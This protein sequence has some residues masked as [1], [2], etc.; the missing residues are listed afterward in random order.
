MIGFAGAELGDLLVVGR[1]LVQDGGNGVVAGHGQV[2]GKEVPSPGIHSAGT[3]SG[4][5]GSE[6]SMA[7]YGVISAAGSAG[8]GPKRRARR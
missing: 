7:G 8:F 4:M 5:P 1:E 2:Q 6:Y 3:W